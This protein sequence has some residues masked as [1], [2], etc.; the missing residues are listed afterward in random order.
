M[1]SSPSLVTDQGVVLPLSDGDTTVGRD[2]GLGLSLAAETT[3]S[4]KHATLT[5][6]G[7][8]VTLQDLGSTNGTFVNGARVQTPVVLRSG[9]AV[10]FGSTKFV[11]RA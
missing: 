11:Y 6:N 10:Q 2:V 4:R 8:D 1:V 9:D 5:K 7:N 3:V